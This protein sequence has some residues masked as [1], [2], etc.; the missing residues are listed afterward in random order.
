MILELKPNL[1]TK[2]QLLYLQILFKDILNL[3][4]MDTQIMGDFRRLM[5][6]PGTYHIKTGRLCKTLA[7]NEGKLFDI[8]M[9]T[10]AL[11]LTK[12]R[13]I[14]YVKDGNSITVRDYPCIN[15]FIRDADYWH[16][17]HPRHQ[18]EPEPMIRI[19]WVIRQLDKGK[20]LEEIQEEIEKIGWDDYKEDKTR[21][22]LEYIKK[23]NYIHPS[24]KTLRTLGYCFKE[25]PYNME[26]KP[27]VRNK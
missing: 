20:T 8:D 9:F 14:S 4:T 13:S 12:Y 16:K 5:R 17:Y 2:N 23:K 10:H 7:S 1:Y 22:Y 6:I 19:A 11:P 26:W 25:C 18:F 27:D 3:P 21:Y 15:R 24:C